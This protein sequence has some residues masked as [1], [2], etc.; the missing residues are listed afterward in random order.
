MPRY[1][2]MVI[3][4]KLCYDGQWNLWPDG[5]NSSTSPSPILINAFVIAV[6]N[7]V[8]VDIQLKSHDVDMPEA[9]GTRWSYFSK[10]ANLSL[11][12][13]WGPAM[14]NLLNKYFASFIVGKPLL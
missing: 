12:E 1:S 3:P 10:A 4:F 11:M 2:H 14:G 5:L 7:G 13:A 8:R 9:Q 6:R